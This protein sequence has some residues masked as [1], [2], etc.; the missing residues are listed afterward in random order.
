MPYGVARTPYDYVPTPQVA[1]VGADIAAGAE[2]HMRL[3]D[4]QMQQEQMKMAQAGE[5]AY[6][7]GTDSPE[8]KQFQAAHGGL[9]GHIDTAHQLQQA[10]LTLAKMNEIKA[11]A[12]GF[13]A[14]LMAAPTKDDYAQNLGNL[15]KMFPDVTLPDPGEFKTEDDYDNWREGMLGKAKK[16]AAYT[17][18]FGKLLADKA[19]ALQSGDKDSAAAIDRQLADMHQKALDEHTKTQTA[20]AKAQT[21]LAK[22]KTPPGT[23]YKAADAYIAGDPNLSFLEGDMKSGS[24]A[25]AGQQIGSRAFAGVQ[26]GLYPDLD[27]GLRAEASKIQP[28]QTHFFGANEVDYGGQTKPDAASHIQP[29]PGPGKRKDGQTYLVNGKPKVWRAGKT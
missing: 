28:G 20:F 14:G 10:N 8:W 3:A 18:S 7:K 24:R 23:V 12:I 26:S 1:N 6:S 2:E 25:R 15:Q 27:T 29:D 21:G 5:D 13:S 16:G 19:L 4:E 22:A 17:S 11:H 9:A